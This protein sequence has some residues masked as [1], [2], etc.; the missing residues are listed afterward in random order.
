MKAKAIEERKTVMTQ[1]AKLKSVIRARARKTGESYTTARRQV[2]AARPPRTAAVPTPGLETKATALVQGA[3]PVR[4]PRVPRG[5]LSN[6]TAIKSTGHDLD[7]WFKVLDEFGKANGHTKAAEFLYSEHKVQAWHAQMITVTWERARGL[8][9][10]N[11]SC[12]GTFQV[13]VSRSIAASTDWIVDFINDPKAR[14]EWL[15]ASSPALRK[16]M[17]DAFASGKK[18]E[19]K[20]AGYARMR[21]RWLS[22]VVELRVYGKPSEKS[23]IVAD[24]SDLPDADAVTVRREAFAQAL[25]RLRNIAAGS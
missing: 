16:A 9:Q 13:S 22:S 5:E 12:T 8:R 6:R 7:Y 14:K 11:Q 1:A 10:E 19:T 18:M 25:D 23:S 3:P 21:Y 24:S 15:K 20:K 2:V 4:D 17:E